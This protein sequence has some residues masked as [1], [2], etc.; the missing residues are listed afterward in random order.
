MEHRL[1]S[2]SSFAVLFLMSVFLLAGCGHATLVSPPS[3]IVSTR[4]AG[5]AGPAAQDL[6]ARRQPA[7][8]DDNVTHQK[9]PNRISLMWP[10]ASPKVSQNFKGEDGHRKPHDGI[11]LS[12][13][14]GTRIYAPADGKVVY[15]GH[16]FH[17]YGRMI[18]IEHSEKLATIFG[19]LQKLL[20][21]S[22]EYVSKGSLIGFVGRTGHA[23]GSHLHFEVRYNRIPVDPLG[24]M[25]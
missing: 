16:K 10:I 4:Q 12:A 25:P 9:T 2:L 20:V 3:A 14:K 19:H 22:G 13:P 24:Y 17:G 11:D 21:K 18:V 5:Q 7:F 8:V 6:Q 23:T 1:S 15:A